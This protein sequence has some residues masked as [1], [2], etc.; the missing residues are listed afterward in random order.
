[1]TYPGGYVILFMKGGNTKQIKGDDSMLVV[2][3]KNG[4]NSY[5]GNPRVVILENDN[6]QL[7]NELIKKKYFKNL[8]TQGLV[9]QANAGWVYGISD[10]TVMTLEDIEI[11]FI[12]VW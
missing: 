12:R 4:K 3:Y 10:N 6:E 9:S 7:M 1:L 5:F 11:K 2:K 8:K